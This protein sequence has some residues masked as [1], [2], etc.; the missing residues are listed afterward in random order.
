[1]PAQPIRRLL[2]AN[3]GEIA[4]R[5]ARAARER[6]IVP[7]GVYSDADADAMF[8][9]AM[10]A[11]VRIG[12]AAA[13]E[14]YLD[15]AA[16]V[17]AAKTLG[18]DAVHPG[19]GF[20]SERAPFAQACIDAGLT[21][22]GP[23]PAAIAQ[24]GSKIDAKHRARAF[25]VPVIPGYDGEDQSLERLLAEAARIGVPLLIKA[26]A[27]GGGRG[28]RVVD[29][30]ADFA[31][32]L[33]AAKREAIASFGDDAILL[34][35]YLRRPRHIE[36]QIVGDLHGN[37]VHL[38]ERE[39]SI[40]RRHQ[41]VL[42]EAP[43]R[44]LDDALRAEM[45]AAAIRAAKSVGYTNAGTVEFMLDAERRF[46]FLEVNARLQVE[47][48]ITELVTG[49]DLVHVQFAIAEGAPL[50]FTQGEIR[51]RGWAI[52]ARVNAED[53]ARDFMPASGHIARFSVP[54]AP[55]IRVDAGVRDGSNI[56][57]HYDSM[58]AKVIAW[59]AT[60][61]AATH[62]LL[63][64]LEETR[65]DGIATNVP[66]LTAILRDDAFVAGDTTTAFL[67]E[68]REALAIEGTLTD[69][70]RALAIGIA[71]RAGAS[72]RIGGIGMP[73]ALT[74]AGAPLRAI[75]SRMG[76]GFVI[77]G[78]L[79][80]VLWLD[81]DRGVRFH[82]AD[83]LEA[84][85]VAGHGSLDGSD[86]FVTCAGTRYE[87]AWAAPPSPHADGAGASGAA[88]GVT[89]PMPGKIASVLVR[90]GDVVAAKTLLVVLEAMK[91]EHRIEA[92]GG[93]T[94]REV[95]VAPGQLVPG[96]AALVTIDA[97]VPAASEKPETA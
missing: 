81:A 73:V 92:P 2:I 33:D 35:R 63:G 91:M 97:I 17:A 40:Q 43:S 67:T 72:W 46:Y 47:H 44:A 4:V 30:L 85:A 28:M 36:F 16:V 9:D 27:G 76:D 54:A 80:G 61:E 75:V 5:I 10:E 96:G 31:T 68:R 18:A 13:A 49:I 1:M 20:L 74:I 6:G 66:L 24:M 53:P 45:G 62:R 95:H 11:S 7:L 58:I 69:D 38:G 51:A 41:K 86:S 94:V 23:T 83:A 79:T 19:Y 22:V 93:G 37:I 59:G 84:H 32:A 29:D 26:S 12:P 77:A 82:P 65:I 57:V 21:F 60:R 52:E 15:I 14:S 55:G 90:A 50:P 42:E 39:C 70:V 56:S 64:A 78:D 71:L 89:A 25:D 88:G 48:P 8:R 3:R 34:E 87:L